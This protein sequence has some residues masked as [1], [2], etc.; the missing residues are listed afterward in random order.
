MNDSRSRHTATLLSD[1]R[2]LVVGGLS[3][4]LRAGGLLVER[5]TDAEVYDP[6]ADRWS[7]TAPMALY[8]RDQTATRL[9]DGRVLVAGSQDNLTYNSTEIY[10]PI[11][12]R[13]RVAAPMASGRSGHSAVLL[14]TGDVLV[15]GGVSQGQ[16]A[17]AIELTSAEVYHPAT[18][19]WSAVASMSE[20]HS[21]QTATV[22]SDGRVL[23]LGA[24]GLSRAE[25]YDPA[26]NRWALTGP[27]MDRYHHTATRL[28]DGRVLVVGGYGIES[29]SSV[30]EYDPAGVAP[31]SQQPIDVRLV[32][33]AL[34][35]ALAA[36]AWSIPAVRRRIRALRP[37]PGAEEWIN[38]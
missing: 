38:P 26:S 32:L 8:R 22:L 35:L 2:V 19:H 7:A 6:R 18:D 10:N 27:S 9:L 21:S 37:D 24:T 34:L 3:V 15:V 11:S 31:R 17:P 36:G 1:G 25:L 4:Q 13:W 23:V 5:P 20:T 29:L 33:A 14:A 30:M 12:D 16:N 28:T